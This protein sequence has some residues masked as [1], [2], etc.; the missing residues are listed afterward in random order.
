[1]LSIIHGDTE[2]MQLS[3]VTVC[4]GVCGTVRPLA[5][6]LRLYNTPSLLRRRC[7]VLLRRRNGWPHP[8]NH[9]FIARPRC[10]TCMPRRDGRPAGTGAVRVSRALTMYIRPRCC[11]NDGPS[12]SVALGRVPGLLC[13]RHSLSIYSTPKDETDV[14]SRP[15]DVPGHVLCTQ[16]SI[17]L[18]NETLGRVGS[19]PNV[20]SSLRQPHVES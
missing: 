14:A 16:Q 8:R 5:A 4:P 19:W 18:R 20:V 15:L 12:D 17:A 3:F 1:M 10:Q 9:Q 7:T 11:R 2:W 13:L 6:R